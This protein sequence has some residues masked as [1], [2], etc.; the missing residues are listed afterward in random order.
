MEAYVI[1]G[2]LPLL[3]ARMPQPAD[4]GRRCL[5]ADPRPRRSGGGN[6]VCVLP[7]IRSSSSTRILHSHRNTPQPSWRSSCAEMSAYFSSET[8]SF[9]TSESNSRTPRSHGYTTAIAEGVGKS[10]I[11]T[12]LIKESFVPRVSFCHLRVALT[13]ALTLGRSYRRYSMSS[14]KSPSR[15]KLRPR[16]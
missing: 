9:T 15:Q 16:T 2:A 13:R 1:A 10:T 8:V 12:S 14:R 3:W 6:R 4:A 7:G 11:V 5:A